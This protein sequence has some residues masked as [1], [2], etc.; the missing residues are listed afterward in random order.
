MSNFPYARGYV[1]NGAEMA[2]WSLHN[3]S[4]KAQTI[5]FHLQGSVRHLHRSLRPRGR[6]SFSAERDRNNGAKA[7]TVLL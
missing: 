3:D 4:S 2:V 5:D 7:I 6:P 1:T